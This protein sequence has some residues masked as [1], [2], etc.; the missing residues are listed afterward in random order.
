M[1]LGGVST[2]KRARNKAG[3][4]C[5]DSSVLTAPP[6]AGCCPIPSSLLRVCVEQ[7]A[8]KLGRCF[9]EDGDA[10]FSGSSGTCLEFTDHKVTFENSGPA[11]PRPSCMRPTLPSPQLVT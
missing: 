2:P 11:A 5:V 8:W 3:A 6:D 4:A 1:A 7:A 9:Q 10:P